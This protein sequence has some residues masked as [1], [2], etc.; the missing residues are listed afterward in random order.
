M[1][2]M[3]KKIEKKRKERKKKEHEKIVPLKKK[4]H[5]DK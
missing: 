1:N 2:K 5:F 4:K 3:S